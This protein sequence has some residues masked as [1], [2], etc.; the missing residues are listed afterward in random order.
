MLSEAEL[1]KFRD[2]LKFF[3]DGACDIFDEITV[4]KNSADTI[5]RIIT[6]RDVPCHLSFKNNYFKRKNDF[7][8]NRQS[9]TL[10]LPW[11]TNINSNSFF[12]VRQNNQL[13]SLFI[14]GGIRHYI[15]HIEADFVLENPSFNREVI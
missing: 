14:R 3:F 7:I 13:Y 8:A 1:V 9:G 11:N 5:E 2:S 6:A 15:S 10:F 12:T 4:R